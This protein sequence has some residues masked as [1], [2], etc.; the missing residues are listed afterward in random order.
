MK[1]IY[2]AVFE[3]GEH[4]IGIFFPDLPGCLPCADDYLE[5][6]KNARECLRLHIYGMLKDG[7]ELPVPSRLEAILLEK[8]E[9]L[10]LIEVDLDGFQPDFWS[11]E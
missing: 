11:E 9:A 1:F 7:D 8:N 6:F 4:G 3:Q 10:A 2:P 5:A